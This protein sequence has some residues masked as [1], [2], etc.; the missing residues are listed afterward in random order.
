MRS[1]INSRARTKGL[2]R[3]EV[4][5]SSTIIRGYLAE[6]WDG[7]SQ[8]VKVRLNTIGTPAVTARAAIAGK[9]YDAVP[10][11][12]SCTLRMN[13]GSLELMSV[14]T[15][16]QG[17]I[18]SSAMRGCTMSRGATQSITNNTTTWLFW[19]SIVRNDL[20]FA[21]ATA[22]ASLPSGGT[23]A[24]SN[25]STT[26][27]G[28]STKFLDDL[29]PGDVIR[30]PGTATEYFSVVSIE[31]QTSMTVRPAA[32]NTASGQTAETTSGGISI[33]FAGWWFYALKVALGGGSA[34]TQRVCAFFRNGSLLERKREAPAFSPWYF[35]FNGI[36]Y[37]NQYDL[38][39]VTLLQDSGGSLTTDLAGD[40][41]PSITLAT[42]AGL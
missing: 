33:P 20:D 36:Y 22:T 12:T 3:S 10:A 38:L 35:N 24:K 30:I 4:V 2:A 37:F 11:G 9:L 42:M 21:P 17:D 39:E 8:N 14:D 26:I 19:T 5:A 7:K 23:V 34:G 16:Q 15:T 28:S 40:G 1:P 29:S 31:T 25:G 18:L 27:T 41:Y 6:G 13:R 32:A